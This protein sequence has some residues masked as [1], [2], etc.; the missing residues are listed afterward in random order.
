MTSFEPVVANVD[1]GF[2]YWGPVNAR[3]FLST[4][5]MNWVNA[6]VNKEMNCTF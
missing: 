5:D 2:R 6:R 1:G 4:L 3:D